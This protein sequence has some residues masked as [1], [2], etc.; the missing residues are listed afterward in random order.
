MKRI[1]I[2]T[3]FSKNANDAVKYAIHFFGISNTHI[4]FLH[5]IEPYLS[6]AEIALAASSLYKPEIEKAK[7][8]M[9]LYIET[10]KTEAAKYD[11]TFTFESKVTSEPIISAI[12]D[13]SNQ[14]EIDLIVMGTHGK[15]HTR[16]ET[17]M[18]SISTLVLEDT[19][20]PVLLVPTGSTFNQF[21]NVI[22]AT[23]LNHEDPYEIWRA[24]Q[25]LDG[26]HC[27]IQCLHVVKEEEEIDARKVNEIAK[28]LEDHPTSIQTVFS[29]AV[30]YNIEAVIA[31]YADN[32]DA[33][34]IIMTRTKKSIFQRLLQGSHTSKMVSNTHLPLLVLHNS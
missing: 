13:I 12:R 33:S 1:L 23:D 2:P 8:R 22:F 11:G 6:Q 24:S 9:T 34:M 16:I 10:W 31:E 32:Y 21:D 14:N 30:G 4:I 29:K 27:I 7:A 25:I 5:V 26:H 19:E 20:C 15:N 28:Y 18:G 3:D 17:F